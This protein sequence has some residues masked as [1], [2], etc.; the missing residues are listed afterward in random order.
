MDSA[1]ASAPVTV[2]S[3]ALDNA[4]SV[5]WVGNL[6]NKAVVI[7]RLSLMDGNLLEARVLIF[8]NAHSGDSSLRGVC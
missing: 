4:A 2:V 6:S 1:R 5:G 3:S 7:S 8:V